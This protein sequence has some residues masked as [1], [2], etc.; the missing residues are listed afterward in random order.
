MVE[1]VAYSTP[2][3][4]GSQNG[5]AYHNGNGNGHHAKDMDIFADLFGS[6]EQKPIR[7]IRVC[8]PRKGQLESDTFLLKKLHSEFIGKFG[9]DTFSIV[10]L[11]D[12]GRDNILEFP[13]TTGYSRDLLNALAVWV[14]EDNIVV[15]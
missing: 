14:G 5:S 15:R 9:E 2:D 4:Q 7:H 12:K 6:A 8:F 13:Q 1:R 3:A 10:V 11:D